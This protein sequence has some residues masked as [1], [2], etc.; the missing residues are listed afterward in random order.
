MVFD[1]TATQGR[2]GSASRRSSGA[3]AAAVVLLGA[4]AAFAAPVSGTISLTL[5]IRG[6]DAPIVITSAGSVDVTGSTI[7][8]AAGAVSSATSMT[9]A[10]TGATSIQSITALSIANQAAT[11]SLGG[12]T[13]QLPGEACGGAAP[14][15]ACNSGGGVGGAMGLSGA[16]VVWIIPNVTGIL[17]D[18]DN[19]GIGQGGPRFSP[20][21]ADNAGFTTGAAFVRTSDPSA[22][23]TPSAQLTVVGGAT[24]TVNGGPGM[25]FVS[26]TYLNLL[27]GQFPVITTLIVPIPE[28]GTLLLLAAGIV[29]VAFA[30]RRPR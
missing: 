4:P 18:L 15:E 10:V 19:S 23:P 7:S 3:L 6:T 11:F 1:H 8:I 21:T 29:G 26:P 9:V 22:T 14:G 28:P 27:G 12:I 5:S 17:L 2:F 24:L 13:N 16:I 25:A 30:S 20:F